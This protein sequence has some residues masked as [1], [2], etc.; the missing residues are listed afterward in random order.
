MCTPQKGLI[1]PIQAVKCAYLTGAQQ[2]VSS[3]PVVAIGLPSTAAPL[4]TGV[5]ARANLG[6]ERMVSGVKERGYM[7]TEDEGD[8]CH[9]ANH[10]TKQ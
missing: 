4:A 3:H 6:G 2:K 7:G 5:R 8:G 1:F 10:Q 9:I